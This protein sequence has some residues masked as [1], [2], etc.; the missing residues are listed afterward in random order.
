M[1]V[2]VQRLK[3][4]FFVGLYICLYIQYALWGG[5]NNGFYTL[6]KLYRENILHII[7]WDVYVETVADHTT[8]E[9]FIA[10]RFVDKPLGDD[11]G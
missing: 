9:V 2:C 10:Q 8:I 11:E 5:C 4:S 1:R 3:A 7:C 6:F